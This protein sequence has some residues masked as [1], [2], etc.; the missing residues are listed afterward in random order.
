MG[1]LKSKVRPAMSYIL[2]V[3]VGRVD[4]QPLA[5]IFLGL[6]S[7]L[8]FSHWCHLQI[9]SG[10][11]KFR[12]RFDLY[13]YVL[14]DHVLEEIPVS[15][16]EFGVFDGTSLAWWVQNATRPEWQFF[17]FDTFTGLPERWHVLAPAGA[18][19][20]DGELPSIED[21]R[22][23]FKV[24][25]FQDTLPIFLKTLDRTRRLVVSMD[26]DL[27]TSTSYTLSTLCPYLRSG[28]IIFF[29]DF[30]HPGHEFLAYWEFIRSFRMKLKVLGI[31]DGFRRVAFQIL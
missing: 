22:C 15:L 14:R 31:A 13:N 1:N 23:H 2:A 10:V 12:H 18:Y 30:S 4:P 7:W 21:P 24:G 5:G 29:D 9:A 6:S 16:L 27:Y 26:A 17:G 11:P 28:D 25:L 20:T 3:T 19:S 8:Q